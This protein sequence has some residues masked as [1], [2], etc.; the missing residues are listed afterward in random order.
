ML[1]QI[2]REIITHHTYNIWYDLFLKNEIKSEM[3]FK[4]NSHLL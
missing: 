3:D 1:F 4:K 2:S